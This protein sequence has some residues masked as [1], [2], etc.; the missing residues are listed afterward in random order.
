VQ[1]RAAPWTVYSLSGQTDLPATA[2]VGTLGS[3]KFAP[4]FVLLP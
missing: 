3:S 1:D 4:Q 2:A